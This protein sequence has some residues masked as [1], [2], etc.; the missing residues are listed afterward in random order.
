MGPSR[1][2]QFTRNSRN[3]DY[4]ICYTQPTT[5]ILS[6]G[7]LGLTAEDFAEWLSRHTWLRPPSQALATLLS[8]TVTFKT[9]TKWCFPRVI[10]SAVSL[11]KPHWTI[12]FVPI[13]WDAPCYL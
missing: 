9:Q 10:T 4:V 2:H 5:T 3:W 11:L 13:S 6:R 7:R 12:D 8:S 1:I